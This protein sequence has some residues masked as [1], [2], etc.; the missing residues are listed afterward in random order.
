MQTL[1]TEGLIMWR[2]LL[3]GVKPKKKEH[4]QLPPL[5][6]IIL[7]RRETSFFYDVGCFSQGY[8][9]K[10]QTNKTSNPMQHS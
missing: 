7:M 1:D 6:D 10:V 4:K 8:F 2:E 3:I 9:I 5:C